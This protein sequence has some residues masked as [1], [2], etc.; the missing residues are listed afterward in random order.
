MKTSLFRRTLA[1][2][3]VCIV[4]G[5]QSI[6][7]ATSHVFDATANGN[8]AVIITDGACSDTSMCMP[9]TTIGLEEF[10]GASFEIYP[11]PT[12]GEL[13]VDVDELDVK[14]FTLYDATGRV[15]MTGELHE[16]INQISI[17]DLARGTYTFEL[18]GYN[19]IRSIVKM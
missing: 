5:L 1:L 3:L 8:Y 13:T 17:A 12:D 4:L 14:S 9:I 11:N 6:A 10:E 2:F 15:V 19:A 7:G 18:N 16:G